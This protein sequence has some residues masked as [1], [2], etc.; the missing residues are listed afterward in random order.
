MI[1]LAVCQDEKALI[2]SREFVEKYLLTFGGNN[3]HCV[4]ILQ[5]KYPRSKVSLVLVDS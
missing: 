1:F 4:N 3:G 2:M 5:Y